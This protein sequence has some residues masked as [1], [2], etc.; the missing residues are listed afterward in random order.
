MGAWGAGVPTPWK[1]KDLDLFGK[2]EAQRQKTNPRGK[3]AFVFFLNKKIHILNH[4]NEISTIR[5][6][7]QN[8]PC[9]PGP[10]LGGD[11]GSVRQS[12]TG[13]GQVVA[14]GP[15]DVDTKNPKMGQNRPPAAA[16]P[17]GAQ[18]PGAVRGE[19][20][21]GQPGPP[22]RSQLPP[23]PVPPSSALIDLQYQTG[24]ERLLR[25]ICR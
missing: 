5:K 4:D 1:R 19:G 15:Q 16:C 11:S 3:E 20:D 6:E 18:Q 10:A 25:K 7:K 21:D 9:F 17:V 8:A 23:V 2:P 24:K 12:T 22:V 13:R 14:H